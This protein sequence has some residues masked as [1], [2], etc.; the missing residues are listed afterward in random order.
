MPPRQG[1]GQW[2]VVMS[3]PTTYTLFRSSVGRVAGWPVGGNGQRRAMVKQRS[4]SVPSAY[5]T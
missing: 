4:A 2:R 5:A 1:E 3:E